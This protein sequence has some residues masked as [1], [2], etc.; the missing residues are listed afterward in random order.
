[1][2]DGPRGAP[3]ARRRSAPGRSGPAPRSSGILDDLPPVR[4]ELTRHYTSV[5]RRDRTLGTALG[6]LNDIGHGGDTV[7]VFPLDR[8]M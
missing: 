7:V 1:M 4:R 2:A 5:A 3:R 8:C 6:A